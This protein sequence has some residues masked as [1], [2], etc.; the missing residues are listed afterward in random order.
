MSEE[1][2]PKESNE[3]VKAAVSEVETK[4]EQEQKIDKERK[5]IL[6]KHA[7]AAMRD[8]ETKRV[9]NDIHWDQLQARNREDNHSRRFHN[10]T[11]SILAICSIVGAIC[12]IIQTRKR[13]D[14][15]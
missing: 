9:R 10:T 15:D 8:E 12:S 4:W 3:K 5:E 7:Q 6:W 1:N 11:N 14:A 2:K 13:Y